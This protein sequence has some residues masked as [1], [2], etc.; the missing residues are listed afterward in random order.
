MDAKKDGSKGGNSLRN[1]VFKGESHKR[2]NKG[3][4]L[5]VEGGEGILSVKQMKSLG[6]ENFQYL[7]RALDNG[8]M[9]SDFFGDQVKLVPQVNTFNLDLSSL[10]SELREVKSAI[11]NKPVQQVNVEQLSKSYTDFIETNIQGNKKNIS[12]YRVNK[13]RL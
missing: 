11:E 5:L 2:R 4:P 6:S 13:P 9:G 8:Y 10:K 7:T 12:R 1:G 3:I